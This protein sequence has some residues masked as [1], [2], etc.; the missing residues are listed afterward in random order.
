M[1]NLEE[2]KRIIYKTE[3]DPQLQKASLR[4]PKGGG[5]GVDQEDEINIYMLLYIKK[6]KQQGP[7]VCHR[8]LYLIFYNNL[9]GKRSWKKMCMYINGSHCCLPETDTTLGINYTSV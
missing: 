8:E 1:R 9:L 5:K 6:D 2:K 4:L 3:I 7:T